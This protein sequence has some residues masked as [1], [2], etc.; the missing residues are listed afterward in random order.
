MRVF[1]AASAEILMKVSTK[2]FTA[3]AVTVVLVATPAYSQ[4]EN[5]APLTRRSEAQQKDDAEIDKAYRNATKGEVAPNAKNDP[6]RIV[7]PTDGDKSK[8]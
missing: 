1:S 5:K 7:R 6:W 4:Q 2:A 3:A 8:R